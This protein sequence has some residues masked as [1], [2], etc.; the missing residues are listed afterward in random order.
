MASWLRGGQKI[1]LLLF[2]NPPILNG[3]F[4][5]PQGLLKLQILL[6]F[7]QYIY[8]FSLTGALDDISLAHLMPASLL[9]CFG[10]IVKSNLHYVNKAL[11][12]GQFIW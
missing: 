7:F 2:S 1:E 3:A 9:L 10:T 5:D 11:L 6:R 8:T 12:P 4:Q